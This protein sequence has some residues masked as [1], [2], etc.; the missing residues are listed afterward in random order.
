LKGPA[1]F[2]AFGEEE[3]ADSDNQYEHGYGGT[4]RPIVGGP[5]KGLDNVGDHSAAGAADEKRREKIAQGED[6]SEGGSCEK[7]GHGKRKNDAEKCGARIGAEVMRGFEEWARD[8]FE[9]SV[10]GEKDERSIDVG[11]HQ[12][13]REGAVKE[14]GNWFVRDVQILQSAV[15]NAVRAEDGLPCI[16]ADEITDPKRNDHELI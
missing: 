3:K 2:K 12:N 5:E 4:E 6:E 9:R 8:V 11:E 1:L 7:T 10:D 16:S 13:D 15:Q 14:S